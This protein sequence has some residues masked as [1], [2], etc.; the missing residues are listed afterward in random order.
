M[1][2]YRI[3]LF[4][5][6]PFER[7]MSDPQGAGLPDEV[8][9]AALYTDFELHVMWPQSKALHLIVEGDGEVEQLVGI[10]SEYL[11]GGGWQA[12]VTPVEDAEN[13]PDWLDAGEQ[14]KWVIDQAT[15]MGAQESESRVCDICQAAAVP[16][17]GSPCDAEKRDDG[18]FRIREYPTPP[19]WSGGGTSAALEE[20]YE[21]TTTAP[22]RVRA[23]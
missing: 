15:P 11:A 3:A 7:L 2:A 4:G 21:L 8:Q 1:A 13:P 5:D 14:A 19:A 18:S 10:V 22:A 9:S 20:E 6:Q 16:P 17:H 12:E 23:T